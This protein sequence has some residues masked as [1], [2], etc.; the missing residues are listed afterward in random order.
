LDQ[1]D[2]YVNGHPGALPIRTEDGK[3]SRM[4]LPADA[5]D[6]LVMGF[7]GGVLVQRRHLTIRG[8]S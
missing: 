7:S 3:E 6:V 5:H 4:R 8:E 2:V 1:L